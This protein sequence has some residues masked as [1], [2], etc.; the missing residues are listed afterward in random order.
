M[1]TDGQTGR[2]NRGAVGMGMRLKY[3][4]VIDRRVKTHSNGIA[5][6]PLLPLYARLHLFG[7]HIKIDCSISTHK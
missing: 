4:K 3:E 6:K 7:A 2:Y 5:F 1:K